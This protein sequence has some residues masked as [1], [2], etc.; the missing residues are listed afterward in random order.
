MCLIGGFTQK[1]PEQRRRQ[2]EAVVVTVG[3][4]KLWKRARKLKALGSPESWLA[5]GRNRVGVTADEDQET[6]PTADE[7]TA[8]EAARRVGN[9]MPS[10]EAAIG[11]QPGAAIGRQSTQG[12]P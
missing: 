4:G 5:R 9:R 2:A 1:T 12:Q 8:T 10:A 6:S 11:R 7:M 3:G